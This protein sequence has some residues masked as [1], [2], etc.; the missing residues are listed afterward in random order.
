MFIG[1]TTYLAHFGPKVALRSR[2]TYST[3]PLRCSLLN[4]TALKYVV[5]EFGVLDG[6][7]IFSRVPV[8][9]VVGAL[10]SEAR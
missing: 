5:P 7:V 2:R 3:A 9:S 4:Q 10:G 1:G 8:V 6:R